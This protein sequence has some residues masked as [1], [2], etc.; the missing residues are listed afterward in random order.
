[1]Q[2]KLVKIIALNDNCTENLIIIPKGFNLQDTS[3]FTFS[4]SQ[5]YQ[6]DGWH[7]N[8]I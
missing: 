7:S 2:T 4:Q 5:I 3:M 1:M 6:C 8:S